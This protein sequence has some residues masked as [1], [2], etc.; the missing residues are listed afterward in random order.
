MARSFREAA[1]AGIGQTEFSKES[2]RSE[3]QLA[4]ECSK[5]ALDDA[6]I[7]PSEVDGMITFTA[8]LPPLA[9]GQL[10]A[11]LQTHVMTSRPDVASI[12]A[13]PSLAQQHA[14]A[15]SALI[16]GGGSVT[17][18]VV[19]HVREDGATLDDGSPVPIGAVARIADD[20]FI[21]ALIHDAE[22]RPINA[23]ERRRHPTARQKRIVKERDRACVDCGS[24]V[25][26]EYD[27][28]P[29]FAESGRTV[30]DELEL[31]C[32]PCHRRRHSAA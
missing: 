7:D 31:R 4:A 8:R 22:G 12:D 29:D 17:T 14:D 16:D 19:L 5:A 10:I 30:V 11:R 28:V 9:A 21:R 13:W 15:L 25:L 24:T 3:L 32:A 1:I 20:A 2:G 6:G 26:L 23:S 18:E 27:H